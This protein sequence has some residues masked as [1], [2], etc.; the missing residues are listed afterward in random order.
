MDTLN[1]QLVWMENR[2]Y[3][4]NN[5]ISIETENNSERQEYIEDGIFYLT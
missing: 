4:V 2:C 3:R 5:Q 1:P